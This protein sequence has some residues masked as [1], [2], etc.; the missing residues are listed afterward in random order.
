MSVLLFTFAFIL[1]LSFI[2]DYWLLQ[3]PGVLPRVFRVSTILHELSSTYASPR[4]MRL[5]PLLLAL[6]GFSSYEVLWFNS[7]WFALI[8]FPMCMFP[9]LFF[10]HNPFF[11]YAVA[12]SPW[13]SI[14]GSQLVLLPFPLIGFHLMRNS[15]ST[16]TCADLCLSMRICSFR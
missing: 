16:T 12:V 6:S 7:I 2:Q 5:S 8:W 10:Y 13:A 15:T 1:F 4:F 3:R 14:T 9:F 11:T